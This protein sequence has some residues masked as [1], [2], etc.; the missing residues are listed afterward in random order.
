[1]LFAALVGSGCLAAA[2]QAGAAATTTMTNVKTPFSTPA[3]ACTNGVPGG[4]VVDFSGTIH[5][6]FQV[7]NDSAGGF[8]VRQLSNLEGVSGIGETTGAKYQLT[9]TPS[10]LEINTKAGFE[11]TL[12]NNFYVVGPGPGNNFVFHETAHVTVNANGTVTAQHLSF[13]FDCRG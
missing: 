11:E 1:M 4:E 10:L 13:T 12:V 8:H 7:T 2:P 5:E 9:G 3:Q 6:V